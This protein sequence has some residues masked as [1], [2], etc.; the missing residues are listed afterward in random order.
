MSVTTL[1]S[2]ASCG[3]NIELFLDLGAS[4]I[5]GDFPV[6]PN[7][8]EAAPRFPLRLAHCGSCGLVQLMDIIDNKLLYGRDYPYYSGASNPVVDH[9]TRYAADIHCRYP[10]LLREHGIVEIACND[11]TFLRHFHEDVDKLLAARYVLGVE[12]ADGP[13][14][15]A[16]DAGVNVVAKPFTAAL[17]ADIV[18][19]RG[20]AGVIVGN[21]VLAHVADLDDFLSGVK[22]LLHKDGVAVFEVQYLLDLLVGN[23]FDLV[24]HEHHYFWSMTALAHAFNRHGMTICEVS[25]HDMQG[26]SIRF[27]ARHRS[28]LAWAENPVVELLRF[29]RTA[30][31]PEAYAGMQGRANRVRT[32]LWHLLEAERAQRRTVAGY[33]A[34]AK[35]TTLF[36]FCGITD[37][38]VAYMVDTTPV[39]WGRHMPG[40]DIRIEPPDGPTKPDTYLLTVSNYLG[41]FVR[42]EAEFLANGGRAIVPLPVPVVI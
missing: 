7:S 33:A 19:D 1:D 22:T 31:R 42:N 41:T 24:Y 8:V 3:R 25:Q 12:P 10:R 13:A 37:V 38:R 11:G 29:E 6:L 9:M 16:I 14:L 28:P 20:R 30:L 26:G 23:H 18:I 32:R 15:A 40:T 2:C 36:A 35:A 21:N 4:P 17:A 5:A 34:S 27:T 39:K